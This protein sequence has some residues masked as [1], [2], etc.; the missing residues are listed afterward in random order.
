MD[1]YPA[2][3]SNAIT[4]EYYNFLVGQVIGELVHI[5]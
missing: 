1:I 4:E 3:Q 5:R 2:S